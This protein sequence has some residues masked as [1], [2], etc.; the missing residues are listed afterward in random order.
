MLL[1]HLPIYFL[2]WETILGPRALTLIAWVL[3]FHP[4]PSKEGTSEMNCPRCQSP[5]VRRSKRRGVVEKAF[6]TLLL[7]RPF[8]C[9]ACRHRFFRSLLNPNASTTRTVIGIS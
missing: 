9:L 6:L 8:R 3:Y 5:R 2:F 1:G 7:V 4:S